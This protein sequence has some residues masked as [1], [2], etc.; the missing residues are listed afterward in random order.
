MAL[1][2]VLETG[3]ARTLGSSKSYNIACRVVAAT[4]ANLR[5]RAA[6]N[7][8]RRDLISRLER[9]RIEVP[10]LR[11]RPKDIVSLA[12]YF[13]DLGRE[14]YAVMSEDL[15]QALCAV[16]HCLYSNIK[17]F[18]RIFHIPSTLIA[19]GRNPVRNAG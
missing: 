14:T 11:S 9:V 3:E 2:R 18:P 5:Q 6:V 12:Q 4:N 16:S 8:F 1:L 17:T 15:R 7:K 19:E 10:P 13:L